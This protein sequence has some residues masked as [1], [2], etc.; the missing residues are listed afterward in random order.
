MRAGR[1]ATVVVAGVLALSGLAACQAK[2]TVAAYVDGT[3][4]T[5]AEIDAVMDEVRRSLEQDSETRLTQ[6]E[7]RLTST[8]GLAETELA[9]ELESAHQQESEW[10]HQQL[11]LT[12]DRVVQMRVLTEAA[13]RYAQ[14]QG[15]AVSDPAPEALAEQVELPA[16]HPYV[17][18]VAEYFAVMTPLESTVD[19]VE[20]T[21]AD[22]REIYDNLVASGQTT[23][24][25]AEAQQVLTIDTIGEAVAVRNLFL[26]ILAEVEVRVDPRYGG[27]YQVPVEFPGG[28]TWLDVPLS[29]PADDL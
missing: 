14:Q 29:G 15:V 11:N 13:N 6:Y 18:V 16:D 12:R 23:V 2:P 7:Q 22:Q 27:V 9:A 20:P 21:E 1:L 17:A 25:F 5:E 3:A 10:R 4:I 8:E 19:P 24:P 28:K 26:D